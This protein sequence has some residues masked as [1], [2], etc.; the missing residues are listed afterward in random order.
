MYCE[1]DFVWLRLPYPERQVAVVLGGYPTKCI[2]DFIPLYTALSPNIPIPQVYQSCCHR[3][4]ALLSRAELEFLVANPASA[5]LTREV[6]LRD[7]PH[8]V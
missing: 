8:L 3:I 6:L 4:V 5:E 1:G 7:Y 2:V